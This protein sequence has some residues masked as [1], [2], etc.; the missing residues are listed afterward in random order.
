[1]AENHANTKTTTTTT[2]ST[3]TI[4]STPTAPAAR[5]LPRKILIIY[6]GGTIGMMS[7]D[8]GYV[9]AKNFLHQHCKISPLLHDPE[10][11]KAIVAEYGPEVMRSGTDRERL[12][13][14]LVSEK[15]WSR[16][17]VTYDILEYEKLLDSSN[18]TSADWAKMATTISDNY[19][20][21]DAFI[22]L[23]GTDTMAY[24]A[25]ALAFSLRYLTKTV[26]ITGSQVPIAVPR[27]DGVDNVVDAL[28]IAGNY[29]IPEV[30][31]VFQHK[32][33]RGCRASKVSASSFDAF[34][35]PNMAPLGVMGIDVKINWNAV[36]I[37]TKVPFKLDTSQSNA[38]TM[39]QL[40]PGIAVNIIAQNLAPPVRGAV[41]RTFGAGNAPSANL[42]LMNVLKEASER[43]VVI[44]NISQCGRGNVVASYETGV[45]LREAGVVPGGDMTFEA[46]LTKLGY[47]LG[48]DR[49]PDD[50]RK[51]MQINLRGELTEMAP[52]A[53]T[54]LQDKTFITDVY[55][56]ITAQ[57]QSHGSLG[58]SVDRSEGM[59]FVTEA[60]SPTLAC[61]AAALG[62]M[63]ELR[64][65]IEGG[66]PVDTH[67]YDDRTP[68]HLAASEGHDVVTAY[69]I[70]K[71]A[72]VNARDR[73]D[74]TP[75]QEAIEHGHPSTAALLRAAGAVPGLSPERLAVKLCNLAAPHAQSRPPPA[76]ACKD[77]RA[78]A[79]NSATAAAAATAHAS[80][81]KAVV[82]K[83]ASLVLSG[84]RA[85]D[86]L[87]DGE[88]GDE[89]HQR[90]LSAATLK[91][92]KHYVEYGGVDVNIHNYDGRT[93][94]HVA[95]S[96]G[97][98]AAVKYL[99][100][101]G[102]K[103]NATDRWG[104]TPLQN[105]IEHAHVEVAELLRDAGGS[106]TMPADALAAKLCHLAAP[107]A[108]NRFAACS[109]SND[110]ISSG[111]RSTTPAKSNKSSKDNDES[112]VENA[113]SL[114]RR[115]RTLCKVDLNVPDYDGRRCVMLAAAEGDE[116]MV[117]YLLSAEA[118]VDL[119]HADRFGL[120]ALDEAKQRKDVAG[121]L[122]VA[123][124]QEEIARRAGAKSCEE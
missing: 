33:L 72:N 31:L 119:H 50:V 108:R 109:C 57:Q 102:A 36:N 12:V 44:V 1:M 115:Y 83:S 65:M 2:P 117:R 120:T 3:P 26:V 42:A 55:R 74:N 63:A 13:S 64:M 113:F 30:V 79:P 47:L 73:W 38:V 105:A 92:L 76:T 91:I 34:D 15:L 52:T 28:F 51:L 84:P 81:L 43:G 67:D 103:V 16:R 101:V 54:G 97:R 24:T 25:S 116:K 9:V 80:A 27:N 106:V 96:E 61:S 7:S 110:D 89:E 94:L 95:S 18:M 17:P 6:T 86:L 107:L 70:K 29:D 87:D 118:G 32:M 104:G 5:L 78:S 71:G 124:I 39:V 45:A 114:L 46:A 68:L 77:R 10:A 37:P 111:E 19:E 69:L 48:Q 40:F 121:P 41:L 20:H 88:E 23:H 8:R 14:P 49:T 123:L 100:S 60:L 90:A 4:T 21:Y 62:A 122:I 56:A 112:V 35:S 58:N 93:P 82:T 59:Q 53:Q 75:L 85:D 99:I 98:V 22:I 66:V 11:A